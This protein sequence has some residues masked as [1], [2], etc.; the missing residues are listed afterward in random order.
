MRIR[1]CVHWVMLCLLIPI[2]LVLALPAHDAIAKVAASD[3]DIYV[4]AMVAP[5]DSSYSYNT[6]VDAA[7]ATAYQGTNGLAVTHTD[8]YGALSIYNETPLTGADYS[9]ISFWAYGAAGGSSIT[10]SLGETPTEFHAITIPAGVWTNYNVPLSELGSPATF[11]RINW[12]DSTGAPQATYY[13]DNIRV[14]AT[15]PTTGFPDTTADGL[16]SLIP[17]P[18]GVAIAPNGRVYVAVYQDGRVYSWATVE[19]MLDGDAPDR[20]FGSANGDPDGPAGCTN[21]P[22]ATMMCGPESVAVGWRW[23]SVCG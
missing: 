9:A 15:Q 22:S 20:T 11:Q 7:G 2:Q 4:D 6:T 23:Q 1:Q 5:W 18:S 14:V 19:S 10:L 16:R 12:Q 13:L 21:G 17:G 8:G 3:V